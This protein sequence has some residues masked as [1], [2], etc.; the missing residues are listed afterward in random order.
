LS[1]QDERAQIVRPLGTS[2]RAGELRSVPIE[3]NAESAGKRPILDSSVERF[4]IVDPQ[5][6]YR[7]ETTTNMLGIIGVMTMVLF[8]VLIALGVH[9]VHVVTDWRG[10]V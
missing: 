10:A 6:R 8:P 4:A 9:A 2:S 7:G 5:I 3:R 1:S